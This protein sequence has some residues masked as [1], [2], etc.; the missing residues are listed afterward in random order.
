MPSLKYGDPE[1]SEQAEDD[2]TPEENAK[3]NHMSGVEIP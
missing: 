1:E 2:Q 3:Y